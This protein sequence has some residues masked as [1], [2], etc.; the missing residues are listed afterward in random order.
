MYRTDLCEGI[1]FWN[2]GE[3]FSRISEEVLL[4]FERNIRSAHVSRNV[5]LDFRKMIHFEWDIQL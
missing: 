5:F 1:F 4:S 3:S 2:T